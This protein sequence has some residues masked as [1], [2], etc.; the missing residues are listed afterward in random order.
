MFHTE[1]L[2]Y[3]SKLDTGMVSTGCLLLKPSCLLTKT[4]LTELV[5]HTCT[6]KCINLPQSTYNFLL[7]P[8]KILFKKSTEQ[9]CYSG[10]CLWNHLTQELKD[11]N[12]VG[13][14]NEALIKQV[15]D[16]S[17]PHGNLVKQL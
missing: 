11:G 8:C 10:A 14:L 2:Y 15:S 5:M 7:N 1:N 13:H 9:T 12:S 4:I 6:R 17:E 16:L 3:I